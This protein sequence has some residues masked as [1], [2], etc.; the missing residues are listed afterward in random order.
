MGLSQWWSP[1]AIHCITTN[2]WCTA[3]DGSWARKQITRRVTQQG[4]GVTLYLA[5]VEMA[6]TNILYEWFAKHVTERKGQRLYC[7]LNLTV[8]SLPVLTPPCTVCCKACSKYTCV[9]LPSHGASIRSCEM[10]PRGGE[11]SDPVRPMSCSHFTRPPG[12]WSL[13]PLLKARQSVQGLWFKSRHD[14]SF[15]R[16]P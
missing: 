9:L 10:W 7:L 4:T 8:S 3:L 5:S 14:I 16:M 13:D 11:G 12:V 2:M 15:R 6:G 1:S